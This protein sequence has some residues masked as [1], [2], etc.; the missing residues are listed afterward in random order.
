MIHAIIY[1][2]QKEEPEF[3]GSTSRFPA[4]YLPRI[5][6]FCDQAG[7]G[8]VPKERKCM[9]HY[10]PVRDRYMLNVMLRNPGTG[11]NE[12]RVHWNVVTYLMDAAEADRLFLC[13][14][15]DIREKAREVSEKLLS[16]FCEEVL[17]A[18]EVEK[19]LSISPRQRLTTQTR[20]PA[21][22]LM[23]AALYSKKERGSY[24]LFIQVPDE[25]D[26][27]LD[28]LL[29]SL[30]PRLRKDISFHSAVYFPQDSSGVRICCCPGQVLERLEAGGFDGCEPSNI[31]Y[32]YAQ[33]VGRKNRVDDRY[34]SRMRNLLAL[35]G[36][37]MRYDILQFAISDWDTYLKMADVIHAKN[38]LR[39]TFRL[40][41]DGDLEYALDQ[42]RKLG[43]E[44]LSQ[45]ELKR[46]L[47]V[48]GGKP[49]MKRTLRSQRTQDPR[50]SLLLPLLL[51]LLE[52]ISIAGILPAV[53]LQVDMLSAPAVWKSVLSLLL[54]LGAG[55]GLRGLCGGRRRRE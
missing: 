49:E 7:A 28:F 32:H 31:Y 16:E 26:Q 55:Y 33:S 14:Y 22:V 50:L 36:R 29:G 23:T 24:K 41:K 53:L 11:K 48:S 9:I 18:D 54:M 30:P 15:Q 17:P 10:T 27:E 45:L 6:A 47:S 12:K 1:A 19:L 21:D 52:K 3:C 2:K 34:T 44:P 13:S 37:V 35:R 46:F 8:A 40:L 39:E 20:I 42:A 43:M 5:Q 51:P 4:E 38:A 25:P